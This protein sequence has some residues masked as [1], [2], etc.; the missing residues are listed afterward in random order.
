MPFQNQAPR[1]TNLVSPPAQPAAVDVVQI[2]DAKAAEEDL[3]P[4][5]DHYPHCRYRLFISRII[6][7]HFDLPQSCQTALLGSLS[8][9][10]SLSVVGANIHFHN[11]Y[12]P[13]H[14]N[15]SQDSIGVLVKC[16]IFQVMIVKGYEQGQSSADGRENNLY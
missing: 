8:P 15:S 2:P 4:H 1:Q 12:A 16:R 13:H 10:L 9:Q 11:E 14:N 3:Q 5:C 6:F 7:P